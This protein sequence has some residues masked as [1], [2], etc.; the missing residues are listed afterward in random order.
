[1]KT[2]PKDVF[3]HLLSMVTLYAS[4]IS[5]SVLVFQL[6]NYFIPDPL[7]SY[8]YRENILNIMRT[9]ISTLII[10][11]PGYL[12]VM[13]LLSKSYKS[14]PAKLG[15]RVRK[16]LIY[17]TL[18]VAAIIII[19]DIIAL[20]HNFLLGEL[21][22]RF[23]IKIATIMFVSGSIFYYYFSDVRNNDKPQQA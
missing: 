6:V 4:A 20:V 12:F 7:E 10:T 16:W 18:F 9:A 14:D 15:S 11:F 8:Y 2:E 5:F 21:T 23:F 1:M 17:F 19:I 22:F 3:L 13:K